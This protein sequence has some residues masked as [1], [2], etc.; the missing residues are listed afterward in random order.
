VYRQSVASPF[1]FRALRVFRAR[2]PPPGRRLALLLKS[3]NLCNL[4]FNSPNDHPAGSAA[5]LHAYDQSN[6]SFLDLRPVSAG[7]G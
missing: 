2:S 4:W 3:V 6:V 5:R 1:F 7:L